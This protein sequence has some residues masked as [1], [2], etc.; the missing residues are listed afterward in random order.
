[1]TEPYEPSDTGYASAYCEGC[2]RPASRVTVQDSMP[3]YANQ[4]VHQHRRFVPYAAE[5]AM[6]LSKILQISPPH[7]NVEASRRLSGAR[8]SVMQ[9]FRFGIK[10]YPPSCLSKA[11]APVNILAVHKELFIQPAHLGKSPQPHHPKPACQHL[12][13]VN[14]VVRIAVHEEA[15]EPLRLR[16]ECVQTKRAA[17]SVP[18]RRQA[19]Y[20][21]TNVA[22]RRQHLRPK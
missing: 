14:R 20:R 6:M 19:H 13:I 10:N 17:E 7:L 9:R 21:M 12:D 8:R 5:A 18:H 11:I 4:L 2:H 22:A 15:A 3:C 1:M 16:K